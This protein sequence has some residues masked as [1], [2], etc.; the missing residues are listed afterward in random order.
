MFNITIMPSTPQAVIFQ[1]TG[2]KKN[3][4][5]VLSDGENIHDSIK[6]GMKENN[7]EKADVEEING[8]LK[9]ASVNYLLGSHYKSRE[10]QNIKV[11]KAF[12]K[13]ELKG[14]TLWGN[15]HVVIPIPKPTTVTLVKG[16][17]SENL[18]IVLS[19]VEL[20]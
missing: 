12:G 20:K 1:K 13:Y 4:V 16:I 6:L 7:I 18:E 14:E 11:L 5:L 15:L 2:E 10:L 19:F 3:L 17:A 9:N 8:V